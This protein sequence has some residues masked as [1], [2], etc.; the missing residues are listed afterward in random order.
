MPAAAN[1]MERKETV[2]VNEK[3]IDK[4]IAELCTMYSATHG[5]SINLKRVVPDFIDGLK[6]VIRRSLYIMFL[7][8]QGKDFR[9]LAS[10]AGDIIG[11][12][13]PHAD[14]CC[15][16]CIIGMSQSWTNSIPLIEGFGN[17]GSCHDEETE[18]L[19]R[20]GWKLFNELNETDKLASVSPNGDN[21]IF[22][23]PTKLIKY[24]YEGKM[25]V[26]KHSNLD[27]KVTPNHIMLL[28][29]KHISSNKNNRY[30]DDRF[31]FYRADEL[32]SYSNLKTEF[33]QKKESKPDTI[34]IPDEY[35]I[36]G[37]RLLQKRTIIPM[38]IWVQF[39]GIYLADGFT[40]I[41]MRHGHEYKVVH[42]SVRSKIRKIKYFHEILEQMGVR[43]P[44]WSE[45]DQGFSVYSRGVVALLESYGL[46]GKRAAEKFIPDFIFDLDNFYIEKFIYAF[47]M[48]DGWR[49][50]NTFSCASVSKTLIDGLQ[51]LALM[52]GKYSKIYVRPPEKQFGYMGDRKFLTQ[53]TLYILRIIG[54]KHQSIHKSIHINEEYY[55]GYVYC[56]EVPT[57][58]TLITRRGNSILV[59]G[60]CSGNEAAAAR[61]I[62]A[63]LSDYAY[64][65]FFADWKDSAVDMV[66]GYDGETKEPLYL[67]AKYPNVLINGTLGIGYAQSSMIP[68]YNFKEVLEAT[69]KLLKNPNSDVVLIPDSPTGASIIENDFKKISDRGIGTYTMRCTYEI[70]DVNNVIR[71]T[72]LP[73]QVTMNIVREKIADIK[74]KGGLPEITAMHDYSGDTID[75]RLQIRDDINPY[76]FI[77][78][79]MEQVGGLEK[80]YPVNI[81]VTNDYKSYDLGVKEL[82][83]EWINYRREQQRVKL[84]N[85][86]TALLAEQRTNDVKIFLMAKDNLETTIQLFKSSRNRQEIEKRLIEKYRHSDIK[87]D[88]LQAKTLSEMKMYELSIESYEKCLERREELDKELKEVEDI[89]NSENGV[90][91]VIIDELREG[92]KKFGSPRKSSIIPYKI[93]TG[94][95]ISGSCILQLS[96]DGIII[97]K[98]CSNLDDDPIPTDSSGFA[99]KV[100]NDSTFVVVDELGHFSMI[101][102][103]EL[104]VDQEVPLNRYIKINLGNIVGLLPYD[105]DSTQCCVL[106]SKNGMLKRIRIADMKPSKR[107]CI[108]LSGN[109]V[110]VR[111]IVVNNNTKKDILVYTE[112]GMG[113]RFDPNTIKVTSI[114]ARGGEGFNLGEDQIVGCYLINPDN[115]YLVYITKRA[116]VRLNETKFLPQ[117]SSKWDKMV[118]LIPISDR[119][120]L[121][122]VIGVNREDKVTVY[123]SDSETETWNIRELQVCTMS[124]VPVKTTKKNVVST[125]VV[126]A[127]KV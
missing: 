4:N 50:G 15:S 88:S 114:T 33:F 89:L 69:I 34:E 24:F 112:N 68:C 46:F 124:A 51:M 25:I 19:T 17:W 13:H 91:I 67:P 100:D 55:R 9:K 71:I 18:V 7:K 107:P 30:W 14:T 106:I 127:K 98:T 102:V 90:D 8:N 40:Q 54:S 118:N 44:E 63:K 5:Y 92:I 81:T 10:I 21:L 120:S 49:S 83:L 66:M 56:A 2:A 29:K 99:V 94:T 85:K 111:A 62:L 109:D 1:G 20:N 3:F 12:L 125:Y 70:D 48:G 96:S 77:K 104:P 116:K 43:N 65:C 58:H 86:R 35:S 37:N 57:Y 80:T 39:L 31:E 108:D 59:S 23:T 75:L 122:S 47:M 84:T 76:K 11:S 74:E 126:K 95:E 82:L 26:G 78:K 60:N 87:M 27:F 101:K 72:S 113:Q 6:P 110:L 32:P 73:Y 64:D 16:D 22:E 105:I 115:E 97:R 41:K 42:L 52:I 119:D 103:K 117:R 38:E 123:Y 28:K 45:V 53:R 36:D 79:L 61:Y 93:S 121:I